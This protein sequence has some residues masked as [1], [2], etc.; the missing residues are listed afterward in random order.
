MPTGNKQFTTY[1]GIILG[2]HLETVFENFQ[3][4]EN[5]AIR[6]KFGNFF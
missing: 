1:T 4:K 6:F 3:V 5:S 2:P